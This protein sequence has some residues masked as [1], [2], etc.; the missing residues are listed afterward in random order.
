M[1]VGALAFSLPTS[2]YPTVPVQP[3]Q[4]DH[5]WGQR[6]MPRLVHPQH[7]V[8][9][10]HRAAGTHGT[11]QYRRHLSVPLAPVR[12]QL[13]ANLLLDHVCHMP[14]TGDWPLG[15]FV[16]PLP[17]QPPEPHQ[18]ITQF[19]RNRD[20]RQRVVH[21]VQEREAL[22]GSQVVDDPYPGPTYQARQGGCDLSLG[23]GSIVELAVGPEHRQRRCGLLPSRLDRLV[24]SEALDHLGPGAT[25]LAGGRPGVDP[26]SSGSSELILGLLKSLPVPLHGVPVDA[27][28]LLGLVLG[29]EDVQGRS[30]GSSAL[31]TPLLLSLGDP[32]SPQPPD[33]RARMFAWAP[34]HD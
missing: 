11:T 5:A 34:G 4:V 22:R 27:Q 14:G 8:H 13:L 20:Q 32:I 6:T 16:W 29:V 30:Q 33:V 7:A 23:P 26:R 21:S 15:R 2:K 17:A 24:A 10:L 31:L 28:G 9:A 18:G 3:L 1:L 12:I 25:R 19:L